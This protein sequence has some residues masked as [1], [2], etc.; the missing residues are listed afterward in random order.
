VSPELGPQFPHTPA[1]LLET[2]LNLRLFKLALWL[3]GFDIVLGKEHGIMP[4]ED[5]LTV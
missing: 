4:A 5:I 3:P 1:F 2:A